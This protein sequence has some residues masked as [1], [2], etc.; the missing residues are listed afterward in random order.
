MAALVVAAALVA[1][2]DFTES[3]AVNDLR[4]LQG[5]WDLV[6]AVQDGRSVLVLDVYLVTFRGDAVLCDGLA[7]KEWSTCKATSTGRVGAIEL[8]PRGAKGSPVR[9]L[10]RVEGDRLTL[11]VN[12][13]L[14]GSKEYPAAL[15]SWEGRYL[16][17]FV[18]RRP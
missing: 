18:R 15:D 17:E 2:D 8:L 16:L 6:R 11:V 5:D 7:G 1:G 14:L 13:T 10:Y 4:R 12:P 9:Y 3:K